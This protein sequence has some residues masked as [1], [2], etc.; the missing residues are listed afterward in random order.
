METTG[1]STL[2]SNY[3]YDLSLEHFKKFCKLDYFLVKKQLEAVG[4]TN[5]EYDGHFGA[6][7][8]FSTETKKQARGVEMAIKKLLE[9][10]VLTNSC[11]TCKFWNEGHECGRSEWVGR[12]YDMRGKEFGFYADASDDQGLSGG[13]KVGPDFCCI[14]FQEK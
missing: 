7:I 6:S 14:L 3:Q 12:R 5:I 10:K 8:F 2:S 9:N 4:A 11:S 1:L 13:V